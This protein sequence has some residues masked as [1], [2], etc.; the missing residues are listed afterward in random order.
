MY[1]LT[2]ELTFRRAREELHCDFG[3]KQDWRWMVAGP[4]VALCIQNFEDD[5]CSVI[6]DP[7]KGA[8][9]APR[10]R[11]FRTESLPEYVRNL[12]E[13]IADFANPSLEDCLEL[14]AEFV[15]FIS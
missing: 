11:L 8:R 3:G 2:F 13:I 14:I 6:H 12:A 7:L 5:T 4:E 10:P 9:K 15:L 1:L